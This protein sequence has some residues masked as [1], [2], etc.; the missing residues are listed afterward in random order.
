MLG[1]NHLDL[2]RIKDNL[3]KVRFFILFLLLDLFVCGGQVFVLQVVC[4][5][6]LGHLGGWTTQ[7]H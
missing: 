4:V 7:C 3:R 2:I 5:F 1:T 6:T